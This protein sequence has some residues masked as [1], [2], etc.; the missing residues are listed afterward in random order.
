MSLVFEGMKQKKSIFQ[1]EIGR[2]FFQL[3]FSDIRNGVAW[4]EILLLPW[5]PAKKHLRKPMQ[6]SVARLVY[7]R[8]CR[9]CHMLYALTVWITDSWTQ[10]D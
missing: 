10:I 5:F 1:M 7:V 8:S 4:M 6:Y 2:F 3:A 9:Q